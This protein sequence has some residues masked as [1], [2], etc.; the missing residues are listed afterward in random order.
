MRLDLVALFSGV[1]L[2][3]TKI[4]AFEP[5]AWLKSSYGGQA[6][7][8]ETAELD[9]AQQLF[10]QTFRLGVNDALVQAWQKIGFE[11]TVITFQGE[12]FASIRELSEQKRGRGAYLIRLQDWKTPVLQAPHRYFD[13]K[14]GELLMQL[15]LEAPFKAAAWNTVHRKEL[16]LAKQPNSYFTAF[17]K[18]QLASYPASLLVQ[19][20]GYAASKRIT[21]SGRASSIIISAG[22][23]WPGKRHRRLTEC[24]QQRL[25]D[26]AMLYP[27][28]TPELGG[29][30]NPVGHVF[31]EA[32][33]DNFLH[34]EVAAPLRQQLVEDRQALDTLSS[35][36]MEAH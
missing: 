24:L 22:H 4:A 27:V 1:L 21:A 33:A 26:K 32:G 7:G 36:L 35:C 25:T 6:S 28:R 31:H 23:K 2:L 5:E 3:S 8:I 19:L 12:K 10:L 30:R 18:A 17:A 15:F 20:H 13:K 9:T 11:L 29:T 14:T 34:L 16:D